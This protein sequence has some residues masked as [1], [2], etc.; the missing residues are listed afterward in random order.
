MET[1]TKELRTQQ[2]YQ[3]Y[4]ESNYDKE[5]D[6]NVVLSATDRVLDL[7]S[8]CGV[9]VQIINNSDYNDS[10]LARIGVKIKGVNN[11]FEDIRTA[12]E[13]ICGF[14]SGNTIYLTHD[15]INPET[16]IH[17]YTH[18][19][20][21]VIERT[22]PKEWEEIVS[23]IKGTPIWNEV[24]ADEKY[25]K[26][27]S[28]DSRV[29]SEALARISGRRGAQKLIKYAKAAINEPDE[30]YKGIKATLVNNMKKAVQKLW[31]IVKS[32]I[33]RSE[34]KTNEIADTILYDLITGKTVNKDTLN[35]I[36]NGTKNRFK[37]S[38]D[39]SNSNHSAGI[40]R[41]SSGTTIQE[42]SDTSGI[43]MFTVG[44][45]DELWRDTEARE[46]NLQRGES[47]RLIEIA[48]E[49][50]IFYSLNECKKFGERVTE[51]SGESIVYFNEENQKYIKL[52]DPYAKAPIKNICA[53]DAIYEHIIHNLITPNTEYTFKGITEDIEGVRI[54]LEQDAI[55]SSE[56]SLSQ[57]EVHR[58]LEDELGLQREDNYF[59]GND[60]YAITDINP[61]ESD[62]V[63]RGDDG[64]IYFIDPLI[65]L[66]KPAPEVVEYL[67]NTR[68]PKQDI[69]VDEIQ[70]DIFNNKFNEELEKQING[71][72]PNN[73]IYELGMPGQILR[74]TGIADLP[75]QLNSSRLLE[76]S[77]KKDHSYNLNEVKNLV[78]EL[79]NPIAVFTYGNK[80]KAQNIILEIQSNE[81]NFLVGLS[82]RPDVEE[83]V[84]EINSIRNVFPKDNDEWLNWIQQDKALY[85]DKKR[86]QDLINQQRINLAEVEYLDLDLV[87]KLIQDFENPTIK[88]QNPRATT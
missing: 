33:F 52:K 46:K 41:Y 51:R 27:H 70:V 68:Y 42:I 43:G 28:N 59:Y 20:C 10:F 47:D 62:N 65:R 79:N 9:D 74:S 24:L 22:R 63:V 35:I 82:I 88:P 31:T 57:E 36:K 61:N 1:Q 86:I 69:S 39:E 71:T 15:G 34:K 32:S 66:K 13:R 17:E 56:P 78:K 30:K 81:K 67:L 44:L 38:N 64:N 55:I 21:K 12:T 29:A 49:H 26:I 3:L 40:H 85:L 60:Y 25:A 50:N 87:T 48:K 18:L 37:Q 14:T 54:I 72:L 73:H 23:N 80:N 19:W 2:E 75:I 76:K 5:Y 84:Y 58:F 4:T 8:E 11:P 53:C 16:P 45:S 77:T 83:I 7:L 6:D